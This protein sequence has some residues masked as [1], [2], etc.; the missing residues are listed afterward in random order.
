MNGLHD[1]DE[2]ID[3]MFEGVFAREDDERFD[4]EATRPSRFVPFFNP[5]V[6]GGVFPG[7]LQPTA[8]GV[9]SAT[10]QTPRGSATV[11]LPEPVVTE[12]VFKEAIQKLETTLDGI[13]K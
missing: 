10:L 11:R 3:E 9:Q 7:M 1:H 13:T 2:D 12:R 5:P 6:R 4:D 8:P